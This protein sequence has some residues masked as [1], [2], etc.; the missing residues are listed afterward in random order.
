LTGCLSSTV[1]AAWVKSDPDD[2]ET[3]MPFIARPAA[4]VTFVCKVLGNQVR[5]QWGRMLPISKGARV[6]ISK[7]GAERCPRIADKQ[8]IVVGGGYYSSVIRVLF[9]DS[10]APVSLNRNYLEEV[11]LLWEGGIASNAAP[12]EALSGSDV[13][14]VALSR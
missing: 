9:D 13:S 2:H 6:R 14:A 7:L 10:R 4:G 11:S 3:A 1:A 8:G 12:T 5:K